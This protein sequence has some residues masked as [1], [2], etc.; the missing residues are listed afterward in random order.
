[1]RGPIKDVIAGYLHYRCKHLCMLMF[2]VLSQSL[3]K[4]K[5]MLYNNKL[6]NLISVVERMYHCSLH[7]SAVVYIS[8]NL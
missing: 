2:R 6:H 8:K 4:T 5:Y 1:M 7:V 3:T